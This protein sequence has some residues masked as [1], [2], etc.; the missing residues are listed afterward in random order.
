MVGHLLPGRASPDRRNVCYHSCNRRDN[1]RA[2]VVVDVVVVVAVVVVG[3]LV[4]GAFSF[5]FLVGLVGVV[6]RWAPWRP[7]SL[8]G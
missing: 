3:V 1:V 8:L 2:A 4:L 5:F 7:L 6:V